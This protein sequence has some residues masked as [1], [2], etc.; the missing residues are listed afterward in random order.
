MLK[1]QIV[2]DKLELMPVNVVGL[3]YYLLQQS[4]TQH[5]PRPLNK[6]AH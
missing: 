6:R 5:K 4:H 2:T 3:T 1:V